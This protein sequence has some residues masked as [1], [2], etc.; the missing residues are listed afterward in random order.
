MR[1]PRAPK[2]FSRSFVV[3]CHFLK[4]RLHLFIILFLINFCWH[5]GYHNYYLSSRL[6]TRNW[7]P[8]P[9]FIFPHA[10]LKMDCYIIIQSGIH[11]FIFFQSTEGKR[12]TITGNQTQQPAPLGWK[13]GWLTKK[14]GSIAVGRKLE[15]SGI[16]SI[17]I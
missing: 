10:D 6:R 3:I 4:K 15:Y 14:W 9:A 1:I 16:F 11:G 13:L 2:N 12:T 8:V 17:I 7:V 5:T